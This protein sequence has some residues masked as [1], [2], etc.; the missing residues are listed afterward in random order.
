MLQGQRDLATVGQL[1]LSE[2]GAAGQR[3]PGRDLP[4][5][6]DGDAPHLRLLASYADDDDER[7]PDRA[8]ARRQA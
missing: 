5:W 6:T 3:A 2:L 4:A 8:A 1:L 7:L